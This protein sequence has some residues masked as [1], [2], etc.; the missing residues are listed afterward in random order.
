MKYFLIDADDRIEQPCFL[1]WYEK[2]R[3]QR[4]AAWDIPRL[5]S[6]KVSLSCETD[7]MDIIS[8][9]YFMLSLE[10][11]NLVRM[12]DETILFKYAVLFDKENRRRMNYGMPLLETVDCLSEESELNRDNSVLRRAVFRKEAVH[13]YTLFQVGRV[14]S[15]YVAASLELVESAFRREVMG[16]RI[17]EA[18]IV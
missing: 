4:H 10:F 2:M 15:R 8:Y 14:K 11:A 6:F 5:N 3:P 17:S 13:D 16:L 7:F 12:Y 18:T 1:D 9:P